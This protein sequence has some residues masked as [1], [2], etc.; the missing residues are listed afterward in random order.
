MKGPKLGSPPSGKRT[1]QRMACLLPAS[2]ECSMN[3]S[4]PSCTVLKPVT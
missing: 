2:H 4:R 1:N 3:T